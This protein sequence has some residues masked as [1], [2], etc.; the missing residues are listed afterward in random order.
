MTLINHFSKHKTL[1]MRLHLM[2]LKIM[3]LVSKL[4]D[5]EL[6]K[7]SKILRE[8]AKTTSEVTSV[9]DPAILCNNDYNQR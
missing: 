4:S 2:H 8:E 7:I 3:E 5:V 6:E 9:P 1:T